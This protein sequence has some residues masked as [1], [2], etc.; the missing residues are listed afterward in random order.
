MRYVRRLV[1]ACA[2]AI[3][4]VSGGALAQTPP[5]DGWRLEVTPYF[6]GSSL[7]G[8][9]GV[10]GVEAD[11][12]AEF[13]DIVENLDSAFMGTIELRRNR[14]ALLFDSIYFKLED[15]GSRSWQGPGGI[16][17]AT[18]SLE[19][20]STMQVYQ[21]AL[22]YRISQEI[23]VDVIAGARY[24]RLD[25]DLDLTAT[26]G[27]LL[28]GGTR[29]V[30][31]DESWWDPL[32]GIRLLI[33]FGQR[34]TGVLYGDYGGFDVGSDSSYQAIAGV[35]WQFAKHF[36][37]KA[38]YRYVYQD[39]EDDGFKWDMAAYGPYLGLGIRF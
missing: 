8:T 24:T 19:A 34:W 7:D 38:G 33:P 25:V 6:W 26:T 28:P 35:N 39:F 16:G 15:E 10:R 20:T 12:E 36:S 32:I 2:A 27:G 4:L 9:V 22:G 17:S 11:V 21:L 30:S 31:G 13:E 37:A 23:P 14:W 18:G 1:A 3:G 29:S 5:E